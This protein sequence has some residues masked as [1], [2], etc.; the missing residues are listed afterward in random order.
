YWAREIDLIP[1]QLMSLAQLARHASVASAWAEAA[2]RPPPCILPHTFRD[3]EVRA[4]CYPGDACHPVRERAL[5]GPTRL[6]WVNGRF[7]PED[8]FEG[9]FR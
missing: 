8:G 7:E 4:I 6:R 2:Q 1:P 9:W 3:G 5:P